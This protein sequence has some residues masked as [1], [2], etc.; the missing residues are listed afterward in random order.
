MFGEYLANK[1]QPHLFGRI[2]PLHYL[3][4]KVVKGNLIL[5]QQFE[6]IAGHKSDPEKAA[7]VLGSGSS[8]N[9]NT[10]QNWITYIASRQSSLQCVTTIISHAIIMQE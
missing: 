1:A 4:V 2:E 5:S 8:G 6:G 3:H 9:L 10:I 7:Q